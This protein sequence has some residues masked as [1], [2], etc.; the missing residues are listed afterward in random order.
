MNTHAVPVYEASKPEVAELAKKTAGLYANGREFVPNIRQSPCARALQSLLNLSFTMHGRTTR[1]TG[2]AMRE[3]FPARSGVL[4]FAVTRIPCPR[5][6]LGRATN[7]FAPV[8][9]ENFIL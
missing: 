5:G 8:V 6:L 2:G 4:P 3:S 7:P 9:P 1:A